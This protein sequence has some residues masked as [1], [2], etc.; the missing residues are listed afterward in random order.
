MTTKTDPHDCNV[1]ADGSRLMSVDEAHARIEALIEPLSGEE[2]V[3]IRAALGRVLAHDVSAT[4]DVP[5]Y[6][7]SAMDGYALR[8]ADLEAAVGSAYAS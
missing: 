8:G 3:A 2:R 6:T 4:V 7:N 5:P 1:P